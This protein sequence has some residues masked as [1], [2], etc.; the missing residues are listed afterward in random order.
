LFNSSSQ[1]FSNQESNI[2]QQHRPI[3]DHPPADAADWI[4]D[5]DTLFLTEASPAAI[6]SVLPRIYE[7]FFRRTGYQRPPNLFGFP[8]P[9][10][11]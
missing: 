5:R 10:G 9:A 1:G 8:S 7:G 3:L 2:E 4:Y 11:R 6:D